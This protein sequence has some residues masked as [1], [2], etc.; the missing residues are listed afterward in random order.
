MF[1]PCSIFEYTPALLSLDIS[2]NYITSILEDDFA[3]LTSLVRVYVW[4]LMC[5]WLSLDRDF[6]YNE[7]TVVDD[8]ALSGCASLS[9]LLVV[10]E[11]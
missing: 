7:I 11:C 4:L 8:N 9:W 6:S 2:W 10:F 3:M 5:R 1:I